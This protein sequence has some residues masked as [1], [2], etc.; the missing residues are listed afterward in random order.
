MIVNV[1]MGDLSYETVTQ[2]Y[3]TEFWALIGERL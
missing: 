1:V 2:Q 3:A